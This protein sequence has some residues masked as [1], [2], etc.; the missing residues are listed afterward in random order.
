M[1]ALHFVYFKLTDGPGFQLLRLLLLTAH[2][3]KRI[4]VF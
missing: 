4:F 2:F 3:E 1:P